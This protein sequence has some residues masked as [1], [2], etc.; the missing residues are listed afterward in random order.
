MLKYW[1]LALTFVFP[2]IETEGFAAGSTEETISEAGDDQIL[3]AKK[4][5]RRKNRRKKRKKNMEAT[6]GAATDTTM[7]AEHEGKDEPYMFEVSLLSDFKQISTTVGDADPVGSGNYNLSG[8]MLYIIAN[9]IQV[10]ADLTYDDSTT[11]FEESESS[12]TAYVLTLLGGYNFGNIDEDSMVFFVRAGFGFGSTSSK[13]TSDAGDVEADA[14]LSRITFALGLH[15]FV[16]SNVALTTEFA[17]DSDTLKPSEG[18]I[19]TKVTTIHFARIGF[20]L[21][22]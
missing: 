9:S 22:I 21:F 16:D 7:H 17:Y 20:S 10:G 13:T 4:R 19:E 18:D 12:D 1:I 14:S 15:Y 2:V 11:K 6:D 3:L 8:R 5:K